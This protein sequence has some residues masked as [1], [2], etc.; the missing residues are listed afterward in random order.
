MHKCMMH[1]SV[2]EDSSRPPIISRGGCFESV[3]SWLSLK[4]GS[5]CVA[6]IKSSPRRQLLVGYP[7]RELG[8]K[9][10]QSATQM[11][12][13]AEIHTKKVFKSVNGSVVA[14]TFA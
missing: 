3:P 12:T 5:G 1:Y 14:F 9:I 10:C 2:T 6:G 4:N 11:L 7:P 8:V 13:E